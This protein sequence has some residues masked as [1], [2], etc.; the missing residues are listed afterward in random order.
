MDPAP[1]L[2]KVL[3]LA[4][5]P[6][7]YRRLSLPLLRHI[8]LY[9]GLPLLLPSIHLNLLRLYCLDTHTYT[10]TRLNI[11]F[12]KGSSLCVYRERFALCLPVGYPLPRTY[13]LSLE[14]GKLRVVQAIAV[15]RSWPGLIEYEEFVYVFGGISKA[16]PL[17]CEKFNTVGKKWTVVPCQVAP[18]HSFTPCLYR[19]EIY[20]SCINTQIEVFTPATESFRS[21][22]LACPCA[23]EDSLSFLLEDCLHILTK[24]GTLLKWRMK[25]SYAEADYVKFEGTQVQLSCGAPVR[26]RG[27]VYWVGVETGKLMRLDLRRREVKEEK[28]SQSV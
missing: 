26:M 14:V 2:P 1:H 10:T 27:S 28:Y 17:Q 9:L 19:C 8:F 3:L 13:E 15:A 12:P 11:V 20:L 4:F 21:V 18:Q 7:P 16:N 23:C 24:E 25:K 22:F 6:V 5:R